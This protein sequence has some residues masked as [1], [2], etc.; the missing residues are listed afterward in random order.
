MRTSAWKK[1]AMAYAMKGRKSK[2]GTHLLLRAL[3]CRSVSLSTHTSTVQRS[4]KNKTAMKMQ[5]ANG[6]NHQISQAPQNQGGRGQ[7]QPPNGQFATTLKS[8]Q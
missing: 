4:P 2:A 5:A 8:V 1:R 7:E 6:Q 3:R